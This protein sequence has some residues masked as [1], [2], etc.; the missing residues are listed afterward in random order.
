MGGEAQET[1]VTFAQIFILWLFLV[2]QRLLVPIFSYL[3]GYLLFR[4]SIVTFCASR[5]FSD[6]IR[7]PIQGQFF[8]RYMTH[9]NAEGVWKF[10]L[11]IEDMKREENL[12]EKQSKATSIIKKYFC[13]RNQGANAIYYYI[14]L[15][16]TL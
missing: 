11:D 5:K 1:K 14:I 13:N 4:Q 7:D 10:F 12:K 2:N 6:V 16:K 8:S 9:K 3:C 15:Y